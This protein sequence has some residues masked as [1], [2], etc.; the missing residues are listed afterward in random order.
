[1]TQTLQYTNFHI[2]LGL[3]IKCSRPAIIV[4]VGEKWLSALRDHCEC[5]VICIFAL[6]MENG[7]T[8]TSIGTS[9]TAPI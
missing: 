5:T 8:P 3:A 4:N 6:T 9:H 2:F 7:M 1:M